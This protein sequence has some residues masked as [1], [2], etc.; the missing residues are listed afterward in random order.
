MNNQK[1][2]LAQFNNISLLFDNRRVIDNISNSIIE[3]DK[4]G[5][6]GINGA[7]KS[8]LLK[9]IAGIIE[10]DEGNISNKCYIEYVP[11][12]DLGLYLNETELYQYIEVIHYSWWEVI[13]YYEN[14]FKATLNVTQPLN[15]LSGGELVKINISMAMF[16]SPEIVLLDEPTNH[17]DLNSIEKLADTLCN[18]DTAFIVISHN[19]DFLN[20]VCKNIWEIENGKLNIYGGNYDFY[21]S[22]KDKKIQSQ[23]NQFEAVKKRLKKEKESIQ[24]VNQKLQK[25]NAKS[26]RLARTN[27]RSI[28][29]IARNSLKGKI[30]SSL[31][32]SKTKMDKQIQETRNQLNELKIKKRKLVHLDLETEKKSGLIISISNGVLTLNDVPEIIEEINLNLYHG[33][34]I[35]IL[36]DNGSGKTTFVKQLSFMSNKQLRGTINYGSEYKTIYINQKY[37]LIIPDLTL[38][39]NIK[40]YNKNINY[41]TIRNLLGN[42]M[43]RSDWEINKY[44][45]KLS[46]G[47][48]ARLAFAIVIGSDIDLLILD[49]PTNNLDIET[50]QVITESLAEFNGTIAAI[51]HDTHFLK[52]IAINRYFLI[53]TNSNKDYNVFRLLSIP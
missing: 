23:M 8:S 27:N 24:R 34:R 22:Q 43:F 3:G 2:V 37:D 46:G 47:E 29:R 9:C 36:G 32:S 39:E 18:T 49:E 19:I 5:L 11:Q 35:A 14:L 33:D 31:G 45:N 41:E 15:T 50:I 28:P 17:L 4:I 42:M 7:G 51:S 30:Q 10:P 48:I 38:I 40:Y 12:L 44:A 6:I 26:D 20:D 25:T 1:K 13:S 53:D 52:E 21:R 16:R